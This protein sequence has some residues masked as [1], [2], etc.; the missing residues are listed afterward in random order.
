MPLPSFHVSAGQPRPW[1]VARAA[2]YGAGIGALAALFK[3]IGPLHAAAPAFARALEVAAV[4]AVFAALCAAA[5][6]LRNVVA[7][8]FIWPDLIN[9]NPD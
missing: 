4:M 1:S 7:R 9:R 6:F 2:A 5:A 8:R 3:T